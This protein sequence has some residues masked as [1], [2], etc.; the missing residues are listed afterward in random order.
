MIRSQL[1][2]LKYTLYAVTDRSWCDA[3]VTLEDQVTAAIKGGATIIQLREKHLCT[4]DFI[5]V[6]LSIKAITDYFNVPLIIN[7]NIEVAKKVNASGVHIGQSDASLGDARRIL[8]SKAIIGVSVRTIDEAIKAEEGGAD[9][10]GVGA[11]FNTSSKLDADSVTHFILGKITRVVAIPVVAI[12]G[13]NHENIHALS[14]TGIA[15]VSVI[16]AIFGAPDIEDATLKLLKKVKLSLGIIAP[17]PR[18]ILTIAGS[19]SSGGA[20]IQ[21]DLKTIEAHGLYGMSVITALTAQNTMGVTSVHETPPSFVIKQM[22]VIFDDIMPDAI[23]IGMVA[24]PE[25][26]IA[27]ANRLDHAF[28]SGQSIPIVLDPVMVATSGSKLLSDDALDALKMKLMPHAVLITPNIP[29]AEILSGLA[30]HTKEDMMNAA[31]EIAAFYHGHILIKGGHLTSDSD[32]LLYYKGEFLWFSQ[33]RIANENTHGT[34]CTLSSA[35]ACA[36]SKGLRVPDAVER[37]KAYVTGAISAE[38]NLGKG[39]GP[40]YHSWAKIT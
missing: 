7:D 13:I 31:K 35:L 29:E 3:S 20:G 5:N 32:D 23:K 15:G 9:Y 27:I 14:G 6:A 30:I 17:R 8:G 38:L 36:L 37:A 12:G 4:D 24:N 34:G 11:V 28:S 33:K 25:I 2:R 40:L 22:D 21:A 26:I 19:D 10:L 39:Q 18:T 16:S 1:E